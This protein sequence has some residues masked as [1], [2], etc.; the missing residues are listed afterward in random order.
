MD[1]LL[2]YFPDLEEKK[3]NQ[4]NKFQELIT[5]WNEKINLISRKDVQNLEIQ[6]LLP[7]LAVAKAL[8]LT[9]GAKVMDVGTGGG[10]PG[11]PLAIFFP[12]AHFHLVDSILK[13][14]DAVRAMAEALGLKNV[15]VHRARAEELKVKVDY[16]TG[17]AVTELPQF[18]SWIRKSFVPKS[19]QPHPGLYYLKGTR[20]K[21]EL[22][23]MNLKTWQ[24]TPISQWFNEPEFEEKFVIHVPANEISKSKP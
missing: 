23:S 7:S 24:A 10:F 1:V 8:P 21:E 3:I 14:T 11:I 15:T 9:D 2:N 19:K 5:E 18:I 12:K 17:R 20:H 22:E 13:K 6:H 4:F 16:I